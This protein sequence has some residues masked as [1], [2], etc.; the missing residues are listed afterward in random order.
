M[1]SSNGHQFRP[2]TSRNLA[3]HAAVAGIVLL[4]F[5]V[6]W[7]YPFVSDDAFISLRYAERLL[8]GRGLTWNDGDTVEG[9]SNLLWVLA[10]AGLMKLQ[11]S[12][13][14]AARA[15]GLACSVA[16][17]VV[18]ALMVRP[19]SAAQLPGSLA[20]PLLL[21]ACSPL[22]VWTMAGLEGPMVMLFALLALRGLQRCHRSGF[23]GGDVLRAGVAMALMCLTRPDAPLW[24]ATAGFAAALTAPAEQV[25]NGFRR[26]LARIAALAVVPALTVGAHT[27]FR[28]WY[29]GDWVP[30]TAHVKAGVS[31]LSLQSGFRYLLDGALVLR[32]L[33]VLALV[34]VLAGW[35][36]ERERGWL[37][38]CAAPLVVFGTYLMAIGGDHFPGWRHFQP[39][40]PMAALLAV[41]GLHAVAAWCRGGTVLAWCL[42]LAMPALLVWDARNDPRTTAVHEE[43]WEWEGLALGDLL[44]RAFADT[45]PLVAVDGA[46]AL[47][48]ASRLPCIDMMGLNDRTIAKSPP[49]AGIPREFFLPGHMKGNGPHVLSLQPDFV[50][51]G[52]PPGL[53]LP[54]FVGDYQLE[55]LPGFREQ[56]RCVLLEV[57]GVQPPRAP[58]RTVK[59]AL[60]TRVEGRVGVQRTDDRVVV[61]A[62]LVGSYRQPRAFQKFP[63][64]QLTPQDPRFADIVACGQWYEGARAVAVRSARSGLDLSLRSPEPAVLQQLQL[65][66]GNW[67]VAVEP[68]DAPVAVQLSASGGSALLQVDGVHACEGGLV[69]LALRKQ[70][71]APAEVRVHRIVLTR[72]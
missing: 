40:L 3:L 54:L 49:G 16:S 6:E 33:F 64:E 37:L 44:G 19:R 50:Q 71:G 56:Y 67:A 36:R 4:G 15:L 35:G 1:D 69:D 45:R 61:P 52:S 58:S 42:A 2:W 29:H 25:P 32:G 65:P 51:F 30:N 66:A 60:W 57:G 26:A 68:Q 24:C 53:P 70:E 31:L 41:G 7:T 5:Q 39:L 48:F 59:A 55:A 9:Y 34:G 20:A 43:Q 22:A 46:G 27:A 23:A 38:T 14:W 21:A 10:S 11:L 72:R 47:P 17:V 63:W 28:L 62:F 8:Q 13:V 12:A 18:L